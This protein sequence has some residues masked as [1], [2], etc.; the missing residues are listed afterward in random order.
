M[1]SSLLLLL[2]SSA[3]A[4]EATVGPLFAP[5][6]PGPFR[7]RAGIGTLLDLVPK[8]IVETN[9]YDTPQLM[10]T[11]RLGL[12]YGF[13]ADLRANTLFVSN[14]LELGAAWAYTRGR[15][16]V[17]VLDHQG[18][19]NSSYELDDA[20]AVTWGLVNE[21]GLS[22]GVALSNVHLSLTAE[23]IIVFEQ[24]TKANGGNVLRRDGAQIGGTSIM[25]MGEEAFSF[26]LLYAGAGMMRTV[27]DY[28]AWFP[29]DDPRARITY[30]RVMA[31]Y[32]F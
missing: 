11:A 24:H 2:S 28:L 25:F 10:L 14:R 7:W 16:S 21:P 29:Y 3:H 20:T 8:R 30:P 31:G 27:P 17:G 13:S 5:D 18:V 32:A 19:A 4:D 15:F 1:L 6:G 22:V 12:P 26:G 23:A 9:D